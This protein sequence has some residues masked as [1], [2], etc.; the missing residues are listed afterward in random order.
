M[1]WSLF[2]ALAFYALGAVQAGHFLD[3]LQ[4]YVSG[5]R[6]KRSVIVALCATWPVTCVLVAALRIQ[7]ALEQ[8][9]R[10]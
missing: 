4:T 5:P 6:Y 1:S 7:H 3:V 10:R 2:Y 9:G 8:R